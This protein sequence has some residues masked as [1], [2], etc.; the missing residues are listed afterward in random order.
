M[1]N[2]YKRQRNFLVALEPVHVG[3]G[4]YR[5]G[6]VDNTIVR[7]PH[8]NLPKIPGTSLSGVARAYAAL[9]CDVAHPPTDEKESKYLKCSGKG[10]PDG[11]T[12]C[13][14]A[15][16][17]VCTTFGFSR[18][19]SKSSFQGLAAFSDAH[20]LFFPVHSMNGPV[21]IT[22]PAALAEFVTID[23]TKDDS[24]QF[25]DGS[26]AANGGINLGWRWFDKKADG[27]FAAKLTALKSADDKLKKLADD[28][29]LTAILANRVLLIS[30]LMFEQVVNDN[31]E[32]RTSVAI[33]PK[34]GA[35]EDKALF[36]YEALPRGTVLSYVVTAM[37]PQHFRI[38]AENGASQQAVEG[39]IQGRLE[40][41]IAMT[42][43]DVLKHA[44]EGL[45]YLSTL[46][47]G[48]MGTRGFGRV[49]HIAGPV[50]V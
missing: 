50:L 44:T 47:L 48:G 8:T 6:L 13:G 2:P 1:A 41:K 9:A 16:C 40:L 36:S 20:L 22:C 43:D 30:D 39:T 7:E 24:A 26:L 15:D 12:H 4:S 42:I 3:A 34:T 14:E 27:D 18:G 17:P 23:H 46:G 49:K 28:Q 35:A 19:E 21:W 37:D 11:D 38:L 10:G 25:A 31:L 33:N 32:V 5:I 45:A 29:S